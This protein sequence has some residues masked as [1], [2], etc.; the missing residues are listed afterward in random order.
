MAEGLEDVKNWWTLMGIAGALIAIAS[1]PKPFVQGLLIGLGLMFFGAGEW[2]NHPQR[3]EITTGQRPGDY[4]TH[5][6]N[7][8]KPKSFGLLL[9]VL[10]VILFALGVL[11]LF[12]FAQIPLAP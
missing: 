10:G 1:A 8:W 7:P 9:D 3:T 6:T 5:K 4:I 2:I 12:T 11:A